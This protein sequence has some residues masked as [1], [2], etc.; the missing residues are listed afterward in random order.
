MTCEYLKPKDGWQWCEKHQTW[1]NGPH[2][3]LCQQKGI[4]YIGDLFARRDGKKSKAPQKNEPV[5]PVKSQPIARPAPQPAK[6]LTAN[7]KI[8][9]SCHEARSCPNT[10]VCCGGQVIVNIVVDCPRALWP[11]IA[12]KEIS[13]C[14]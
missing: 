11:A 13:S 10:R 8:C 7:E 1:T 14:P 5:A 3:S 2:C 12:K 9:M 6:P 4:E